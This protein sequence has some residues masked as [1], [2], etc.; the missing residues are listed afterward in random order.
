M[1]DIPR[2]RIELDS[3]KQVTH[4]MLMTN[5]SELNDMVLQAL[6][7]TLNQEWVQEQ[8]Q[9]QVNMAVHQA[10]ANVSNNYP[11]KQAITDLIAT[12]LRERVQER[13]EY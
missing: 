1:I 9:E 4:H 10:I 11:L 6:E 5:Q 7:K 2:L 13:G 3:V 12:Q 8:I